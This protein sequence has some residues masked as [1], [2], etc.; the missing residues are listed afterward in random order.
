MVEFIVVSSKIPRELHTQ[1][2]HYCDREDIKPSKFIHDLLQENVSNVVPIHKAGINKLIYDKKTDSFSWVIVNDDGTEVHISNNLSS[3]FLDNL[4]SEL[5][6][7]LSTR[8]E[9]IKKKN[10][11][12][13]LAPAR[14][15]KLKMVKKHARS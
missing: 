4:R 8:S 14:M 15:K 13:V 5:A 3:D 12:S 9:Y 2:L 7:A 1:L 11:R 6:S 10:P